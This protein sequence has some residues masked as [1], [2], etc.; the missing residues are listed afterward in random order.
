MISKDTHKTRLLMYL[1]KYKDITTIQAIQDLGNTRLAHSI[2]ELKNDGYEIET[3]NVKVGTR[4]GTTTTVAK[5][6]LLDTAKK[7]GV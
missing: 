3:E 4:W 7:R 2:W 1:Y 6:T 5:Y